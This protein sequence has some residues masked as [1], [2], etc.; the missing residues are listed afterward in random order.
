MEK[1]FFS[2]ALL[3]L[4]GCACSDS[5]GCHVIDGVGNTADDRRLVNEGRDTETYQNT[6]MPDPPSDARAGGSD[7]V[8]IKMHNQNDSIPIDDKIDWSKI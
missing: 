1:I 4:S 5:R 2:I 7:G 3:L 6:R 8:P